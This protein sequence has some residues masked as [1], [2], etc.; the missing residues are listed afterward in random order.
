MI[1]LKLLICLLAGTFILAGFSYSQYD[2]NNQ[3]SSQIKPS[4]LSSHE[5]QLMESLVNAEGM[6]EPQIGKVAIAAVVLN[7][8]ENNNFPKNVDGIIFE[9]NQFSSVSNGKF[10]SIASD[11]SARKAVLD[12]INGSDPT[13]GCL[14]F[15]NPDK[16]TNSTSYSA[17]KKIGSNIFCK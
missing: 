1:L 10:W 8:L 17:V 15:Y 12:A 2:K 14:Y 3:K 5:I 9:P 7:R 16:S 13:G 4:L 6:M 11:D